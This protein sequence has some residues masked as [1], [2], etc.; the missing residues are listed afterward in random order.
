MNC[1]KRIQ[2]LLAIIAGAIVLGSYRAWEM[3]GI[4]P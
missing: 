3:G 1:T 2:F 4:N